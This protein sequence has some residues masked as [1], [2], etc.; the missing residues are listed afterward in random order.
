MGLLF[1]D[2]ITYG[3]LGLAAVALGMGAHLAAGTL[4][5][6]ALARDH[7]GA[8]AAAWVASAVGCVAGMLSGGIAGELARGEAGSAGPAIL[9]C[10]LLGAV[11]RRP[12]RTDASPAAA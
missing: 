2:D 10:A 11:S 9:L 4:N 12:S 1:T 5:Q 3:R 7:A 6:A 8:A